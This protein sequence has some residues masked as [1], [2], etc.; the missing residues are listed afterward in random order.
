MPGLDGRGS[1]PKK[2]RMAS[3]TKLLNDDGTASMATLLM[4]SHHGLRRDIGRFATALKR[5]AQ[6]DA[7]R[8]EALRAEWKSYHA[9]L[10]GHH[11][12]EDN[13]I[14]PDLRQKHPELDAVIEGLYSDHRHIDPLLERGDA[15]FGTLPNATDAQAL[16]AELTTLLDRHLRV[17]EAEVVPHL[18]GFASFPP[19]PND[20]MAGM[21]AQGFAW[22]M[23]GIADDVLEQVLKMLPEILTSRLPAAQ[24]A[25]RERCERAW[26]DARVALSRTSVPEP[27][28]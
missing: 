28:A 2:P 18:R 27:L 11:T 25:F 21:Y 3:G 22:S 16:I 6:G 20:E 4:M 15:A 9:T 23:Q 7:S 1:R 13:G 24:V 12:S 14:F 10:H 19:P 26:G 8:V 17:E 5:V